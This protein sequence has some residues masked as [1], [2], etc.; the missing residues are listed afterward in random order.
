MSLFQYKEADISFLYL[1]KHEN[2]VLVTQSGPTLYD[3]MDCSPPGS[4]VHGIL[5]ARILKWVAIP[6]FRGSSDPKIEPGSPTLQVESLPS[7]PPRIKRNEGETCWKWLSQQ[8][9]SLTYE[10]QKLQLNTVLL[11]FT[12]DQLQ[13][14][15][16][17]FMCPG[18]WSPFAIQMYQFSIC[19][20]S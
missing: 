13:S 16:T 1:Y 5:Q 19:G 7:E 14:L 12:A 15:V 6:F 9:L 2:R 20:F 8:P 17:N 3:P 10:G 11:V 4:S 18:I